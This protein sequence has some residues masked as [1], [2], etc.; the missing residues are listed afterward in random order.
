MTVLTNSEKRETEWEMKYGYLRE[1]GR[2][3]KR[4]REIERE[5]S[6]VRGSGRC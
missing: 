5:K 4:T 2:E 3:R 1:N 6:R